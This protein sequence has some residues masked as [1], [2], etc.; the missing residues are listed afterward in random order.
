MQKTRT[1][2]LQENHTRIDGNIID[3]HHRSETTAALRS[4]IL[5]IQ[6]GQ[7]WIW[8]FWQALQ[9]RCTPQTNYLLYPLPNLV[10]LSPE[11]DG[12]Q[13]D[14]NKCLLPY[15]LVHCGRFYYL[16]NGGKKSTEEYPAVPSLSKQMQPTMKM[17]TLVMTYLYQYN[18]SL[19]YYLHYY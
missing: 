12:H 5:C 7:G 14:L 2:A 16:N 10:I 9:A 3:S 6:R 4:T 1:L 15:R 18:L 13:W 8:Y 11:L 17:L 19:Y